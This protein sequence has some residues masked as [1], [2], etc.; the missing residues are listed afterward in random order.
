M[1]KPIVVFRSSANFLIKRRKAN[2]ICHFFRRNCPLKHENEGKKEKTGRQGKICK[3]LPDYLKETR[4]YWKLKEE[5][6]DRAVLRTRFGRGNG[7]V[8]RLYV[9]MKKFVTELVPVP[10]VL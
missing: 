1:K 3:Q 9:K 10:F 6:P 4:R 7:P 2:W 5:A 8:V